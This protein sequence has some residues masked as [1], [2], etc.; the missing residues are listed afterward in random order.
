MKVKMVIK[1]WFEKMDLLFKIQKMGKLIF[2]TYK[3]V[4]FLLQ[5]V[6]P[7]WLTIYHLMF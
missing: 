1:K 5:F 4:K 7:I 3:I 2:D 6:A